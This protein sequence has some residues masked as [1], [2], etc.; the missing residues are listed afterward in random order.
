M[1]LHLRSFLLP[2]AVCLLSAFTS[3]AFASPQPPINGTFNY[4]GSTL[5]F[6]P[7]GSSGDLSQCPANIGNLAASVTGHFDPV[8]N[9]FVNTSAS[10]TV[11]GITV[12]AE[13][14]FFQLLVDASG[15]VTTTVR[16]SL[17]TVKTLNVLPFLN[18]TSMFVLHNF[19]ADFVGLGVQDG[20]G[21]IVAF[22][23][24]NKFN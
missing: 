5:V 6:F 23:S 4:S 21:N 17:L 3:L 9:G 20:A 8:F 22:C 19:N 13:V 15:Q 7:P 1:G 18:I 16:A 11:E 2:V 12:P 14:D 10:F 24:Y